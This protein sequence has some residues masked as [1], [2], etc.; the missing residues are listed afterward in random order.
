VARALLDGAIIVE[1]DRTEV[2]EGNRYF[3]PASVNRDY[4]RESQ[5]YTRFTS[6]KTPGI[7]F[8]AILDRGVPRVD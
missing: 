6:P 5:M 2:V 4:L 1:S 8:S 7:S 3:P